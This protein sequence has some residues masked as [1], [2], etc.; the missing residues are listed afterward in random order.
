MKIAN[1]EIPKKRKDEINQQL[2]SNQEVGHKD[3]DDVLDCF[4]AKV[5]DTNLEVDIKLVD[6]ESGP[7]LDIVLFD[8]G[9]EVTCLDPLYELK[10]EYI[11]G[12]GDNEVKVLI[13]F[14]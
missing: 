13:S 14:V 11:I 2:A 7:Y 5:P 3:D 6:T 9:V 12:D 10:E 1:L 8:E 4:T